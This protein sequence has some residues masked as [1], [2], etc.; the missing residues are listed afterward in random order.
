VSN[1]VASW[2]ADVRWRAQLALARRGWV[3]KPDD[4][5]VFVF[6]SN[7]AGKHGAGAAKYARDMLGAEP[8]IGAG[9]M[10]GQRCYALPTKDGRLRVLTLEQITVHVSRFIAAAGCRPDLRF[11]VSRIGC[12]LAGYA[13][14]DIAPLFAGVPPNCDLPPGWRP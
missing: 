13:D 5:R 6:G 14:E 10:R 4:E 1:E 3:H 11:F 12:G 2:A 9:L 7:L 8:G